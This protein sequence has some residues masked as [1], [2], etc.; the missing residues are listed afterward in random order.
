[1]NA[2]TQIQ[3]YVIP[4]T[5]DKFKMPKTHHRQKTKPRHSPQ[6]SAFLENL[7][8]DVFVPTECQCYPSRSSQN[9]GPEW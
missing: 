4:L 9:A 3:A 8:N 5:G 2:A 6:S 7:H 1:M